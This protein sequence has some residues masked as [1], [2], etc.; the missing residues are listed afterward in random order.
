MVC[1]NFAFHPLFSNMKAVCDSAVSPIAMNN[2]TKGEMPMRQSSPPPESRK[3]HR[4]HFTG[5][6]VG[7]TVRYSEGSF[8]HSKN[9]LFRR[10][11]FP[12][13]RYSEGALIRK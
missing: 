2:N 5:V 1:H 4:M 9:S 8:K 6:S 7:V 13:V 11:A 3:H 10:F 12:K